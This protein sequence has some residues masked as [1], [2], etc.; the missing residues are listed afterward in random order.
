MLWWRVVLLGVPHPR[1]SGVGIGGGGGGGGGGSGGGLQAVLA[2]RQQMDVIA[3]LPR[4]RWA[5]AL[6]CTP[7]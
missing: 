3:G 7:E 6:V 5:L 1:A 4:R 2:A